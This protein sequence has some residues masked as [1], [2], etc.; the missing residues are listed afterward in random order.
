MSDANAESAP[1]RRSSR[2]KAE[3]VEDAVIVD[4]A[5]GTPVEVETVHATAT[6]PVVA[7][8]D[9]A[10]TQTAAAVASPAVASGPQVVYVQTPPPPKKLG[11]RGFGV[12]IAVLSGLLFALL[13]GLATAALEILVNGE[14]DFGFFARVEFYIPTLF[15]VIA[16]VILVLLANRANW[17]A[18]IL[19]SVFVAVVVYFG[20]IGLILL[21]SGVILNTPAEAAARFSALLVSPVIIIATLLAREVS[22]WVGSVIS[23]R[24]RSVKVRNV[25]ARAAYERELAEKRAAN[26]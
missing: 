13:V 6:E 24:G 23:R 20:S 19:G 8:T 14:S 10:S 26:V 1:T 21:S 16:F 22:L 4:D 18:Y 9:P 15:F 3:V 5:T 7:S 2:A 17:W 25:E 11:N 12:L